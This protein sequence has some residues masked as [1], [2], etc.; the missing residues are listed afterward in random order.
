MILPYSSLGDFSS[1]GD[2]QCLQVRVMESNRLDFRF[3]VVAIVYAN[4]E[5]HVPSTV[6]V[7]Y[8]VIQKC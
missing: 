4:I 7:H 5:Y 8:H 1:S 6:I 2:F 3:S